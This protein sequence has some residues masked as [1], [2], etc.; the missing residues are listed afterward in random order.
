MNPGVFRASGSLLKEGRLGVN[1][2]FK[3]Y[4]FG[5]RSFVG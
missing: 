5:E 4:G 3:M 2:D 1:R